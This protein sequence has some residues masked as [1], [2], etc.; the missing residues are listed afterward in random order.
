MTTL[1]SFQSDSVEGFTLVLA[2]G[3]W[4]SLSQN[5]RGAVTGWNR[6]VAEGIREG[7]SGL[8]WTPVSTYY[9]LREPSGGA[10]GGG[11]RGLPARYLVFS[12]WRRLFK[13]LLHV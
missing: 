13:S 6:E 5:G 3:T 1:A 11:G 4:R 9:S 10:G 12:A 7:E 2:R 8:R